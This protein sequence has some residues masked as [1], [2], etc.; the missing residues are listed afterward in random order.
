MLVH[1]HAHARTRAFLVTR[2]SF[3]SQCPNCS[4]RHTEN[5]GESKKT[6]AKYCEARLEFGKLTHFFGGLEV[7]IG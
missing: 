2:S 7:R 5:E 6:N 4:S 1:A 3:P